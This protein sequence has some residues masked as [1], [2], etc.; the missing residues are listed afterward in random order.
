MLLPSQTLAPR[1]TCLTKVQPSAQT[2]ALGQFAF[3]N[4]TVNF[5]QGH[6]TRDDTWLQKR[7]TVRRGTRV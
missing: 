4:C 6:T 2:P 3:L 5:N 7:G 1:L